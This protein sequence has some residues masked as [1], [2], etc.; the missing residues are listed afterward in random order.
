MPLPQQEHDVTGLVDNR[1]KQARD[2]PPKHT[3]VEGL[4]FGSRRVLSLKRDWRTAFANQP[5]LGFNLNGL[6][7][8]QLA[9]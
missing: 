7:S 9:A 1:R 2:V 3:H 5:D 8:P 4:G 6:D